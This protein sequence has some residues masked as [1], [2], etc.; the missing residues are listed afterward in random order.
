MASSNCLLVAA[1]A[2]LT[3]VCGAYDYGYGQSSGEQ[4]DEVSCLP[5]IADRC[6][7][8]VYQNLLC[9][10]DPASLPDCVRKSVDDFCD[11]ASDA[12]DCSVSI[13]D[14]DCTIAE[15]SEVFDAWISGLRNVHKTFCTAEKDLLRVLVAAPNCWNSIFFLKCVEKTIRVNS[16]VDLM[17]V[18]LDLPMC[19][20][21]AVAASA[22]NVKATRASE[23]CEAPQGAI[24]EAIHA[25]LT[26]TSCRL[27][28][29]AAPRPA[30][31][32]AALATC[33]AAASALLLQ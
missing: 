32:A 30:P 28:C 21:I 15:G 13:V 12:L 29:S 10:V 20:Q 31:L 6:F 25:F 27:P 22:C 19:N 11:A 5:Q 18:P 24:S 7:R 17:R 23:A 33:L 4:Y 3:A 1:V 26:G 2:T 16:T 9:H 14:G 8:D